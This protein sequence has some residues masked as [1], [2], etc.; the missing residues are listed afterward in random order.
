METSEL[1]ATLRHADGSHVQFLLLVRDDFWMGTSRLF[2]LLEIN[3]D[4][5]RNAR[6]VDLFDAQHARRV[7]AMFGQAFERLPLRMRDLTADHSAF[8]DRA[9]AQLSQ[10]G[11]VI[12]VRLSLFADLM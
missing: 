6:A 11:R 12:P 1:T 4:R 7:L 10:D 5:D 8:L 3:L 2:E 9:V